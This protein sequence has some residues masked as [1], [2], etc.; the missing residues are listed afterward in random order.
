MLR[1][2][3]AEDL[4]ELLR[5]RNDP[6]TRLYRNDDR[7]ITEDEHKVWFEKNKGNIFVYDNKGQIKLDE[8]GGIGWIVAPEYRNQGVGRAMLTEAVEQFKPKW[9]KVRED[10]R[11]SIK[12]ALSCG[13]KF[14]RKEDR[15]YYFN[16]V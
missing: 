15:M 4:D 12:L 2:A 9:C 13:F 10:N 16:Y 7:I 11:H 6:I 8:D 1:P 14:D 3:T 5:W